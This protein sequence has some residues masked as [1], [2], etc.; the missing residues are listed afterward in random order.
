MQTFLVTGGAGFIGSNFIRYLFNTRE[1][2]QVINLDKLTYAG[3]LENLRDLKGKPGYRFSK[4]D[5][6][7]AALIDEVMEG[8]QV[9]VNF[10]AESHV[11][12]SIGGPDAFIRTDVYGAF[13]LLEAARRH[14]VQKFIQVSTDEVYGSIEDGAFKETDALMPSSP[15]SA[16]KAGADRLAYSY[17]V[18]YGLPVVITRCSN[19]FGPYQYPE[20]LIPLFVTNAVEGKPLPVYGD[21]KNVRDWIYVEDHCSAI[22][23]LADHG[24]DGEVYNIG[25]SNERNNLQITDLILNHL[26]KPQSLKTFIKDRLGH[27]RRY[28]VD[29]SKIRALGWQPQH[30]FESALSETIAWYVE[31]R[32]WWEKLK[33]G[34]YLEY[35]KKN[36]GRPL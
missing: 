22:D 2:V 24:K 6:C 28:A 23:F 21:G 33:S 32:W 15:Y 3:N 26:N 8:V 20:K 16:S 25:G 29:C 7:D 4:G 13:V 27:D 35:Y 34:E 12:R 30:D 31:N 11:D 5:I 1:E 10:A 17:Y 18:T 9:V 36:Y 19:N 14:G